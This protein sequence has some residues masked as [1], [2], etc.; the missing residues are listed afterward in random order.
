MPPAR[1]VASP[2]SALLL[3]GTPATAH[4]TARE[5]AFGLAPPAAWAGGGAGG[6]ARRR[7]RVRPAPLASLSSF[8]GGAAGQEERI[9]STFRAIDR[10]SKGTISLEDLAAYAE[11]NALPGSYVRPYFDALA[12]E[13]QEQRRAAARGG[14]GAVGGGSSEELDG[15]VGFAAFRE[16]VASREA[17]L[18]EA[19]RQFDLDGDGSISAQDLHVSLAR[20]AVCSGPGRCVFRSRAEVVG[21]LLERLHIDADRRLSFAEFRDFFAL[22]P[23]QS[24]LTEYWLSGCSSA[25]CADAGGHFSLLERRA[26]HR[27]SPWGH[28]L[29][30]AVAGAASR[31]ATAPLETL[32]M[33]AMAG[34]MPPGTSLA[35]A[36]RALLAEGGVAAL[37]RG[38]VINVLRSAPARAIDFFGFDTLAA[39]A[40]EAAITYGLHDLIKRGYRRAHRREPGVPFSLLA[41]AFASGC[42]QLVVFPLETV[43]RRMQLAG[44]PPPPPPA[45]AAAAAAAASPAARRHP[46]RRLTRARAPARARSGVGAAMLRLLPSAAISFGVYEALRRVL[47]DLETQQ[48]AALARR[49]HAELSRALS[50][51]QSCNATLQR[52]EG[53]G[54]LP[55]GAAANPRLAPAAAGGCTLCDGG[56]VQALAACADS[57]GSVAPEGVA[58]GCAPCAPCGPSGAGGAASAGVL[59]VAACALGPGSSSSSSNGAQH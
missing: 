6:G 20:V 43:S 10:Q 35:A 51:A 25:E 8:W 58:G 29:A 11:A 4:A 15:E 26:E 1:F 18:R 34:A 40:P 52:L 12:E 44:V 14:G 59:A 17:G 37:Y 38:N 50:R 28:L 3:A 23:Q 36:A 9:R 56:G 21:Q 32:R 41:G 54:V 33:A 7:R 16:F 48:A 42:G 13:Q 57:G 45:A 27:G 47:L 53:A 22:L 30:G 31:T 46:R 55:P 19:F 2:P 39:I 5:L 49:Q 24:L